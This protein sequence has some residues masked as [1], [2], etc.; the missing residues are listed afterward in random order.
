MLSKDRILQ[1]SKFQ[2]KLG[3]KFNNLELLNLSLT[4]RSYSR[5]NNLRELDNQRLEFLGDAVIGLVICEYLYSSYNKLEE[6]DLTKIKSVIVSKEVIYKISLKLNMG[7]YILFGKSEIEDEKGRKKVLSD[8]YESLVG[9]IYLDL[10]YDVAKKWIISKFLSD[11]K[12]V[13][14]GKL[15]IDYKSELQQYIQKQFKSYPKYVLIKEKGPDHQKEFFI[16][17]KFKNKILGKGIGSSKK[18]AE[19]KAAKAAIERLNGNEV[20]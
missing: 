2:K 19:Q 10:G 11:I 17:I 12:K 18:E 3:L 13:V 20:I 1:L 5:E 15:K 6:G 8:A 16:G 9:A 7:M 4:H 14:S